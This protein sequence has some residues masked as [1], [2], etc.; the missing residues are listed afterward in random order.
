MNAGGRRGCYDSEMRFT[1]F[2]V[3]NVGKEREGRSQC[4]LAHAKLALR[5]EL[6]AC[7]QWECLCWHRCATAL[8][9]REED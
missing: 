1:A 7:A 6:G 2:S 4:I 8:H 9:Q 5:V 3:K